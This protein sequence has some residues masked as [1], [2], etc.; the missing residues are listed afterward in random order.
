DTVSRTEH[1]NYKTQTLS[2]FGSKGS[3][4]AHGATRR[5]AQ[6]PQLK[7]QQ[8]DEPER[9]AITLGSHQSS[10]ASFAESKGRG[11][12]AVEVLKKNAQSS[13]SLLARRRRIRVEQREKQVLDQSP[14]AALLQ[15]NYGTKVSLL[16][17]NKQIVPVSSPEGREGAAE[18][19]QASIGVVLPAEQTNTV[20][21]D[22]VYDVPEVYKIA[23]SDPCKLAGTGGEFAV[24]LL[25]YSEHMKGGGVWEST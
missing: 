1:S 11:A 18:V 16:R 10:Q 13:N 3:F 9:S 24:G 21:L 23:D 17:R 8:I 25:G 12:D 2:G 22:P 4:L 14:P 15:K 6:T 5:A 20:Q 7:G 19:N